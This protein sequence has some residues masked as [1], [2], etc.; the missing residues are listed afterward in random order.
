MP[1]AKKTTKTT[2]K[3]KENAAKCSPNAAQCAVKAPLRTPKTAPATPKNKENQ[4]E[5]P[6]AKPKSTGSRSGKPK[7]DEIPDSI[8]KNLPDELPVCHKI[9]DKC[10]A[11]IVKQKP[12]PVRVAI[13]AYCGVLKRIFAISSRGRSPLTIEDV[14]KISKITAEQTKVNTAA[15]TSARRGRPGHGQI[16]YVLPNPPSAVHGV[17]RQVYGTS[18][19]NSRREFQEMVDENQGSEA[20][21]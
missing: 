1:K 11:K 3:S 10:L 2:R 18:L 13:A 4:A 16:P 21:L 20:D 7:K 5:K 17:V 6:K 9:F 8:S 12:S 14:A 19:D 15:C